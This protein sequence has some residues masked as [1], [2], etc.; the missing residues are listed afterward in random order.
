MTDDRSCILPAR[1]ES[2]AHAIAFVE[3]FSHEHGLSPADGLR[4]TLVVEELLTNTVVHGHGG[5]CDEPVRIGLSAGAADVDLSYRDSAPAFDP[6]EHLARSPID[7]DLA[8]RP[9]GHVGIALIVGM[10]V[11]ASYVRDD[12]SNRLNLTLRRQA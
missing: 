1:M 10:A 11:R 8:E 2:L 5:D 6:L 3:T 12:G 4:L 7:P 9:V